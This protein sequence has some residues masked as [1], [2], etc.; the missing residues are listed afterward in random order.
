MTLISTVYASAPSDV[1]I[2]PMFEFEC[3]GFDPIRLCDSFRDYTVMDENG[4][5]KTFTASGFT[6]REPKINTSGQQFLKFGIANVTGD[7]QMAID[8]ALENNQEIDVTF[9]VYISDDLTAPAKRPYKMK[10]RSG[11]FDGAVLN[12]DAGYF[13]LL[14]Y[15]WPRNRY[16]AQVAPGLRYI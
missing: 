2:I 15:A 16:T 6:H 4:V 3:A 10:L 1:V 8:S 11:T 14:N 12:I 9:R 13:D 5:E 7:A